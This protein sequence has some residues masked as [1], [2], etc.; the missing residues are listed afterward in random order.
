MGCGGFFVVWFLFVLGFLLVSF[1][2]VFFKLEMLGFVVFF[3]EVKEF[4]FGWSIFSVFPM[5]MIPCVAS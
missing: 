2:W 1:V 4:E 3:F 5:S